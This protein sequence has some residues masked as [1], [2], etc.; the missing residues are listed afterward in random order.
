MTSQPIPET[1]NPENARDLLASY[2][3]GATDPAEAARAVDYLRQHPEAAAEATDYAA[4]ALLLVA[5]VPRRDPPAA[6]RQKLLDAAR[7][8]RPPIA[9][10]VAAAPKLHVLP[11]MTPKPASLRSAQRPILAWVSTAAAVVLLV[12]NM[13]WMSQVNE[14]RAR[15]TV[16]EQTNQAQLVALQQVSQAQITDAMTIMVTGTKSELVDDSGAMRAMVMWQP[17]HSEALMFTHSLPTL[18]QTRTYQL[19]L[20][21][22]DGTPISAGTFIVDSDGRATL[23]FNAQIAL[24]TFNAFGISVE[25][26]GGSATPTTPPMA[27]GAL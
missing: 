14:L 2:A 15:Q 23:M 5:G 21:D 3:I 10:P 13:F 1:S 4:A 17:G 26:L 19:W 22:A 24:D 25:P 7:A 6:M 16:L 18:D 9:Q 20:I 27:V 8:Q 12:M 11:R